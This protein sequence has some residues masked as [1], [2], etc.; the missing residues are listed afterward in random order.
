LL[1]KT[2]EQGWNAYRAIYPEVENDDRVTYFKFVLADKGIDA[3][4]GYMDSLRGEALPRHPLM[5]SAFLAWSEPPLTVVQIKRVVD[6]LL[7]DDTVIPHEALLSQI[8]RTLYSWEQGV[9][10]DWVAEVASMLLGAGLPGMDLLVLRA[11]LVRKGQTGLVPAMIRLHSE[12]AKASPGDPSHFAKLTRDLFAMCPHHDLATSVMESIGNPRAYTS[13][14]VG[15]FLTVLR[16]LERPVSG[17]AEAW[18]PLVERV[19]ASSDVVV[20][21]DDYELLARLV[22]SSPP[23]PSTYAAVKRL[24]DKALGSGVPINRK[25]IELLA[26]VTVHQA[27]SERASMAALMRRHTDVG[28]LEP[29][30]QVDLLECQLEPVAFDQSLADLACA[31]SPDDRVR[32]L[33]LLA[34]RGRRSPMA[35]VRDVVLLWKSVPAMPKLNEKFLDHVLPFLEPARRHNYIDTVDDVDRSSARARFAGRIFERSQDGVDKVLASNLI[36]ARGVGIDTGRPPASS[37]VDYFRTCTLDNVLAVLGNKAL[38]ERLGRT[39]LRVARQRLK[40]AGPSMV[41]EAEA[42]A[43][44]LASTKGAPTTTEHVLAPRPSAA[45]ELDDEDWADL[46]N[47]L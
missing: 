26:S 18:Q 32:L 42:V 36:V 24:F 43:T 39:E 20:T 33:Q 9:E 34:S 46:L 2:F 14:F 22:V 38:A 3:A 5:Y 41:L 11:V 7:D 40:S 44:R 35:T 12:L 28:L 16:G 25:F 15:Y 17:A 37:L 1:G 13:D 10:D 19:L 8:V 23:S 29:K 27:A 31:C 30:A 47:L 4:F 21:A 6:L 45:P